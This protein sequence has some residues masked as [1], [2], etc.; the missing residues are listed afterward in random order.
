MYSIHHIDDDID[1]FCLIVL[2]YDGPMDMA[3]W[4]SPCIYEK[5][6]DIAKQEP[7]LSQPLSTRHASKTA[8]T[9]QL[10]GA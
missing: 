5:T 2:I 6:F 8:L 4:F 9:L 10:V 3:P 7:N 1:T